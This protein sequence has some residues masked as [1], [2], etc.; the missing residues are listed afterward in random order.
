MSI[1][2]RL[3][4]TWKKFKIKFKF[5]NL[6]VPLLTVDV[7]YFHRQFSHDEHCRQFFLPDFYGSCQGKFF[8]QTSILIWNWNLIDIVPQ[9]FQGNGN[10]CVKFYNSVGVGR[11]E[12]ANN[13]HFPDRKMSNHILKMMSKMWI[14]WQKPSEFLALSTLIDN[15]RRKGKDP[16]FVMQNKAIWVRKKLVVVIRVSTAW[17]VSRLVRGGLSTRVDSGPILSNK[18]STHQHRCFVESH[19]TMC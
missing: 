4:N 7:F 19:F 15:N 14:K 10:I 16:C 6:K 3:A 18:S 8:E 11:W 5:C 2:E 12:K 13:C 1:S 9:F 17:E